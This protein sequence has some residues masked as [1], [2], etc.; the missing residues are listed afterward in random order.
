MIVVREAQGPA[1]IEDV[2]RLFREYEAAIAVDLCFQGFAHEL[3]SLPGTYSRPI[4]R[5]LLALHEGES[6]GC[7]GL[8]PLQSR[9]CEMKRLYVRSSGRRRGIG[10]L[11]AT[12]IIDQARLAGYSRILLDTLTSMTEARAL[13]ASL[14]FNEIPPYCH[15]PLPGAQYLALA[16]DAA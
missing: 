15:N 12:A 13:Y 4:G 8:R 6:V 7:V 16:L 2:R 3:T 1:D 14:G 5:L 11:L 10:R 9:D